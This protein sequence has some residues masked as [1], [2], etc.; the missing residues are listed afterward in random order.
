MCTPG[1][2]IGWQPRREC[3]CVIKCAPSPRHYARLLCI[4]RDNV[5]T[6]RRAVLENFG[7]GVFATSGGARPAEVDALA[8]ARLSFT[9]CAPRDGHGDSLAAHNRRRRNSWPTP[10]VCRIPF[11]LQPFPLRVWGFLATCGGGGGGC[12]SSKPNSRICAE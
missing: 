9:V 5:F 12:E 10:F 4:T 2:P 3:L 1:A 8:R 11:P 6:R 7:G